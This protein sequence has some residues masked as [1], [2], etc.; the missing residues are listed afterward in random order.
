MQ[1]STNGTHKHTTAGFE[2]GPDRVTPRVTPP[3]LPEDNFAP[4]PLPPEE[5]LRDVLRRKL[6]MLL[7]RRDWPGIGNVVIETLMRPGQEAAPDSLSKYLDDVIPVMIQQRYEIPP[8]ITYCRPW[9]DKNISFRERGQW[10]TDRFREL[11]CD[12]YMLGA[13]IK[14]LP[15][16]HDDALLDYALAGAEK[17]FE[18]R[19]AIRDR[20]YAP[21]VP[22]NLPRNSPD[23]CDYGSWHAVASN[24]HHAMHDAQQAFEML[25]KQH[26]AL[27][28]MR[29][30]DRNKREAEERAKEEAGIGESALARQ[31][32]EILA[33]GMD[34]SL[35]NAEVEFLVKNSNRVTAK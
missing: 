27:C 29:E 22:Y 6:D 20:H 11:L 8:G 24:L 2:V 28:R 9:P 16:P 19:R 30:E 15:Q 14:C 35:I 1:P 33:S 3:P 34:A 21:P 4:P 12:A 26:D 10:T 32:R 13:T 31:I 25:K 7:A 5:S 18:I 23:Y 17:V